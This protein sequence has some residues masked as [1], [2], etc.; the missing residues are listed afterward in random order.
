VGITPTENPNLSQRTPRKGRNKNLFADLLRLIRSS[1][2]RALFRMCN[3]EG[4][5]NFQKPKKQRG[6]LKSLN[7]LL[8]QAGA[9]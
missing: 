1:K 9:Y 6:F 7:K 2:R 4:E 8:V 5:R 3:I